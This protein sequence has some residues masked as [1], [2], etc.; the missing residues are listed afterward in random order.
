LEDFRAKFA[1][2]EAREKSL[3]RELREL[4]ELYSESE[5]NCR[6]FENRT[7]ELNKKVKD[8][9]SKSK[10]LEVERQIYRVSGLKS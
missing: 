2:A 10:E 6:F 3:L 1:E 8:L 5:E 4:K 9:E 7:D